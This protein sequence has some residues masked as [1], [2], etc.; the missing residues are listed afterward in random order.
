MNRKR[1]LFQLIGLLIASAA[2]AVGTNEGT[3]STAG[4]GAP[5]RSG[6]YGEAPMLAQLVTQGQL[7]SVEQRLP[8]T[9]DVMRP[10]HV[11]GGV[12]RYGGTIRLASAVSESSDEMGGLRGWGNLLKVSGE[13]FSTIVPNVAGGYSVSS[14]GRSI[15]FNL[16]RGMRWSDG[17]PFTAD[18]VMFWYEKILL[19]EELTPTVPT[20]Y[21]PGGQPVRVV[22]VDNY[23]VRFDFAVSYPS[24][25]FFMAIEPRPDY[26]YAP[27]HYLK[28]FHPDFVDLATLTQTAKTAGF[29]NWTQ[30]FRDRQLPLIYRI[31]PTE[32]PTLDAYVITGRSGNDG[33]LERNPYYWRVD[34]AGNQLPYIDRIQLRFIE[35]A[36]VLLLMVQNGEVDFARRGLSIGDLP[37]L[38]ANAAAG[39][40]RVL[41][42]VTPDSAIQA[43][44][45]NQN[46]PDP[47]VRGIMSDVRFR[48]ALSLGLDRSEMN[49]TL[50]LG[51]GTPMQNTVIPPTSQYYKE[52]YAQAFAQHDPVQAEK[53]LDEVGVMRRNGAQFR[54]LPDGSAFPITLSVQ[55]A[56]SATHPLVELAAQQWQEIG[57]NVQVQILESSLFSQRVTVNME[58]EIAAFPSV[59]TETRIAWNP[60]SFLPTD[61][62]NMWGNAWALW[63]NTDG[64]Q[65]ERPPEKVA[66]LFQLWETFQTSPDAAA[67][68]AAMHEIVRSQAENLWLIGTVGM[69]PQM[70]VANTRLR[71][72]PESTSIYWDYGYESVAHPQVWYFAN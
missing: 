32:A 56:W 51:A 61:S 27:A 45:P 71:N 55:T 69:Y 43:F 21:R 5:V 11:D 40:Y 57:L 33:T 59:D 17:E 66:R 70:A 62:Y 72:V 64:T 23:T 13:D 30:L 31:S 14:D 39:Q 65:G 41:E 10:V 19:N 18:D 28:Q 24:G 47:Q 22:R 25:K 7:P 1:K 12:G 42:W 67:R 49:E 2:F 3:G 58:H 53:L 52:E 63:N 26:P 48:Q 16:R 9:P 54:T 68:T 8:E 60:R 38:Q 36:E 29:D 34:S 37:S 15:T 6:S 20:M 44:R 4:S 50:L 46:H 35:R